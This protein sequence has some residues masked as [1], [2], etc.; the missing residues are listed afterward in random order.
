MGFIIVEVCEAN[1]L[2]SLDLDSLEERYPGV[3]VLQ[4]ECM[5]RCGLCAHNIYAYVN[6]RIVFANDVET[7]M[8]RICAQIEHDMAEM[9]EV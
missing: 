2:S 9:D 1:P 8:Q 4:S 3:S 7:C 6:G 5:S